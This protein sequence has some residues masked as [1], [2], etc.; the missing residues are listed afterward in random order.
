[1]AKDLTRKLEGNK[2]KFFKNFILS[3]ALVASLGNCTIHLKENEDYTMKKD[4]N[5]PGVV[6][7]AY[8]NQPE[9]YEE[10]MSG[11]KT[12]TENTSN[13]M[14]IQKW[15]SKESVK[16]GKQISIPLTLFPENVKIPSKYLSH[17]NI[18]QLDL[19]K[20]SEHLRD[21]YPELNNYDF[22]AIYYDA[23]SS[24]KG[25]SGYAEKDLAT[26]CLKS[27]YKRLN[28]GF[29]HE[30]LHLLGAEDKE[31][32]YSSDKENIMK[33]EISKWYL[34][35]NFSIYPETAEEIGWK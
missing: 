24:E 10:K 33:S 18:Y 27:K 16:Y 26:F 35:D 17:E 4:G 29:A 19:E 6:V 31:I 3:T 15:L 21:S 5:Y 9:S 20:F 11:F 14:S 8:E 13:S 2:K 25:Y 7:F 12:L 1:M 30:W 23:S 34:D 22:I 28:P 32:N